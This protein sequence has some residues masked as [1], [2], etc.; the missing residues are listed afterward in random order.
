[1]SACRRMRH[2]SPRVRFELDVEIAAPPEDVFDFLADPTNVPRWQE[3][4]VA[5][6]PEGDDRIHE[7]RSFMG[8]TMQVETEIVERER[9]RLFV[10]RSLG[11]PVRFTVRHELSPSADGTHLRVEAEGELAGGALGRL[12]GPLATRAAAKQFR[13]DFER[14]QGLLQRG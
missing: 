6:E 1:M 7:T 12:A 14:L 3:S 5:A 11:G 10:V 9:P 8:R 4:C 2:A 13:E